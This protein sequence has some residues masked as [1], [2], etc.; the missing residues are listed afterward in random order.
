[1][2]ND[3]IGLLT[4]AQRKALQQ[5]LAKCAS[6]GDKTQYL[7]EIGF[8]DEELEARKDHTA[9]IVARALE[10]DQQLRDRK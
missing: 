6:C 8:P 5:A 2:D 1:M 10:V 3:S 7:R 9:S 4:P